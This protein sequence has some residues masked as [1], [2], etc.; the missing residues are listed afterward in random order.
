MDLSEIV[1]QA[2]IHMRIYEDKKA[3][4]SED[5]IKALVAASAEGLQKQYQQY[6]GTYVVEVV[7]EGIRFTHT[8]FKKLIL[9]TSA[10]NQIH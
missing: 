3:W 1:K 7:F 4:A 6:S 8:N 2:K 9:I 5:E 10:S